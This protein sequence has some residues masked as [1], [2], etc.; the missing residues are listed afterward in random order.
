MTAWGLTRKPLR[1]SH[2]RGCR[3]YSPA[4]AR[5]RIARPCAQQTGGR[6]A[7]FTSVTSRPGLAE[8]QAALRRVATL[9][10]QQPSPQEVF[11]AVTEAVGP[12]LGADL[13]FLHLF[14]G[15]GT[16]ATIAS[17]SATS[18]MLPIATR[19]P[20]DGDSVAARIFHTGTAARI[21]GY[22]GVAG[23]VAEL[24]RG[25]RIRSTVGAPI[26]VSGRLWGALIAATREDHPLPEDAE[27]RIA[28]FTGLV[29][30]AIANAEA[31]RELEEVAAEQRAL[32][33]AA[34]LVA[35]GASATEVF[36]AITSSAAEVFG[37]PFSSLIRVGPDERATMVAGCT[38]CSGYVGTTWEVPPNDTG[39]AR[40][41]LDSRR[42][43]RVDDHS[44]VQGPI[45][46]AARALGVGSVVG[47]P[48]FVGGSVWGVMVVGAPL[49]GPPLPIDAG[50]RLI[51]FTELVSTAIA[52]SDSKERVDLL[53]NQQAAL[54]RVAMLVA[55]EADADELFSAVSE[56]VAQLLGSGGAAVGRFEAEG[57]TVIPV[58]VSEMLKSIPVGMRIDLD[59]SL[60]CTSVYRTGQTARKDARGDDVYAVGAIGEMLQALGLYSSVAAPIKVA[61]R[62]WGTLI[63]LSAEMSLPP[64]TEERLEKFSELVATAIA[65]AE[66]RNNLAAA[67]SQARGLAEEQAALRRVATLV[68]QGVSPDE[69]FAA[70]ST[71]VASLFSAEVA[72][73]GRFEPTEPAEITAV[74]VSQGPNDFLIGVRSPLMEWLASTVVFRTGRTARKDVT[75]D[76][77]TGEGT[78]ADAIRA[79]GFFSTVSAPIVVEGELWGVLTAS[80]SKETLPFGTE[81]RLES[82][83]E[84]V[85]T[86]IANA[87]SRGELAASEGRARELAKEQA[88]LRRVATLVAEGAPQERFFAAVAREV[89]GVLGVSGVIV[90]H[91][92]ADGMAVVFGEEFGS[93]L[94]EG[95][96]FFG[97]GSRAPSDPGSLAAQVAETH[98][99][100]RIDDFA[101]LVGTVGDLARKA[102]FG[103]GCAGPIM[104]D[105][106]LWGKICV[107][108]E[109]G[110]ILPVDTE[111][112]LHDFI[113]LTATAIASYEARSELAASEAR[114][115]ELADEQAALRRVAVLVAEGASPNEL[116]SAV[117]EEVAGVIDIPVVGVGRYEADGTF[118]MLGIAGRTNVT[119]GSNWPVKEDEIAG[120]ILATGRPARTDGY[121]SIFGSLGEPVRENSMVSTVAVP[122]VVGGGIWGFMAGAGRPGW[123]VPPDAEERLARFTELAATAVSNATTHAELLDSRARVVNAGDET[124][125][126]LERDL[127]DGIQQ[128][129]VALALRAR[130][131]AGVSAAGKSADE[132]LS[133]LAD[134]LV[135]VTDELREIS[136]GIHPAI[137]SDAGLDDALHAL[138][139]RSA[140]GVDL[141]VDFPGRYDPTL[142][143]TV[144]Y[145]TAESITNAVKHA[146]ASAVEVRGGERDGKLVLDIRDNGVGGADP[147]RG[148]GMIGLKDR[149]DTLGGTIS[150]ASP[151][152]AGTAVHLSLPADL[153]PKEEGLVGGSDGAAAAPAS[154]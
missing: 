154:G 108:S 151:A 64:G 55:A 109:A 129:L 83:S 10:A 42:P 111:G 15:D 139:R 152:G 116:F 41:V 7:Q 94:P 34:T 149:V 56:E 87:Q 70:V 132:E 77:I 66:S 150:F 86:A 114:A 62:L 24:A 36:A 105:G 49:D 115:R 85:A 43:S 143:A 71:E 9:V 81:E 38:A 89:V 121:A 59:D 123:P 74:G 20:L 54:R 137:L 99:T 131:A 61:G 68:A 107:F 117:A 145:V 58:G 1:D 35:A 65:N 118:T 153:Q 146:Q 28:A 63:T 76:E 88:A 102:G 16:S 8:E 106:E 78:L 37:V 18:E 90:T 2:E 47:A 5:R 148:S 53:L 32:R 133:G 96:A 69:L 57:P 6:L 91:Y 141:D 97:V 93:E 67:E 52:N 14:P 95:E 29:A 48:V 144:Y 140:L 104:V 119:V 23:E 44:R 46:E 75:A 101:T 113:E 124:R 19:L 11:D 3:F 72:T 130:K 142:E 12:L 17:W 82:F 73:I 126:R 98:S 134:D 25:M 80:S 39:I 31:R 125:R 13:A 84:L 122:I 27:R 128:W 92:E 26:L 120:M 112:R 147:R 4:V 45:G 103:S 138:A 127:H 30:T 110:R 79:M 22:E 21:D 136:R 51:G 100:A 40:A 33:R 60:A 50:E 135:A